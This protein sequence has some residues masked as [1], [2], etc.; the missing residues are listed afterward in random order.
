MCITPKIMLEARELFCER[1][2]RVLFQHL[3]FT[4]SSS[5]VLQVQGS[6]GSG[7]TTL[8]RILCGLNQDYS[9]DINWRQDRRNRQ[10][11][12]IES[13]GIQSQGSTQGRRWIFLGKAGKSIRV[14][15][16]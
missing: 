8:L 7:K 14:T 12:R 9:G 1:D 3:G 16:T 15:R 5:Q 11:K 6:N 2:E 4:L 13:L 10:R